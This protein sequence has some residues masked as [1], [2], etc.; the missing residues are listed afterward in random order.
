[1]A[2]R[3][4]IVDDHPLI[5]EAL[6]VLFRSEEDFEVVAVCT[7]GLEALE[8]VRR[9]R[10]DV[11]VLDLR[12]PGVS[13][14]DVLRTIAAEKLPTRTVLLT[15]MIEDGEML[16]AVRL[17]VSG[18][19]LKEM[20]P[21]SVVQ[22]VRKVHAGETWLE[23]RS[24]ARALEKMVRRESGAREISGLLTP[25]ELEMVRMIGR[26]LRN[27]EIASQ[28]SISEQTVKV[29][30]SRIYAKLGVDGRLALLRYA[31]DKGLL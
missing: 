16:E 28:M 7:Q 14:L 31:E 3:L 17:G 24:V 15:A 23:K 13:G 22:C 9:H 21:A 12:M 20:A 10:P 27:K 19:I 25:R 5:L 18:M 2:I 6:A 29:H 30:L 11:L 1:M 8:A 4:V 26:G